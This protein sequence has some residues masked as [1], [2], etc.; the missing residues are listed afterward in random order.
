M[1]QKVKKR[2]KKQNF[3]KFQYWLDSSQVKQNLT[4]NVKSVIYELP[5][6]L[7]NGLRLKTLRTQDILG[8]SQH[9][10]QEFLR[11]YTFATVISKMKS[12]PCHRQVCVTCSFEKSCQWQIQE[13]NIHCTKT[14]K[15]F[16]WDISEK[17]S[18]T[19]CRV[20]SI[21]MQV[22]FARINVCI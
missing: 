15:L 17:S 12:H 6:G 4:S 5:H 1:T 3:T 8:T 16:S 14:L 7:P 19:E 21:T 10:P 20:I 9:H 22:L 2:K 18:I 13:T 11:D